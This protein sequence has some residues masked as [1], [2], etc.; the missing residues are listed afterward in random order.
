MRR[1]AWALVPLAIAASAAAQDVKVNAQF[2]RRSVQPGEPLAYTITVTAEALPGA[3]VQAAPDFSAFDAAQGPSSSQSSEIRFVN[4]AVTKRETLTLSWRV[5]AKTVEGVFGV[6]ATTVN[7]GGQRYPVP[8]ARVQVSQGAPQAQQ[9]QSPWQPVDPFEAMRQ[10]R[11]RA[12]GRQPWQQPPARKLGEGVSVRT[13]VADHQVWQGQPVLVRD[14]LTFDLDVATFGEKETIEF[15]GFA[16]KRND[17]IK[18]EGRQVRDPATGEIRNEATLAEWVIVPL[19]PGRKELPAHVYKLFVRPTDPMERMMGREYELARQ[20][21][22]LVLDVRPLP[23]GAPASF[24]GA[25]GSFQLDAKVDAAQLKAGDGT[26][27]VV[28]V[29]GRGSFDGVAAPA[30]SLP[31]GIKSFP[32]EVVEHSRFGADGGIEGSK[33]F[34]IPLLVTEAGTHEIPSI[35]WSFF[36]PQTSRYVERRSDPLVIQ[37]AEGEVPI[38]S[39]GPLPKVTHDIETQGMDIRHVRA[40]LPAWA[41]DL[42]ARGLPRWLLLLAALGPALN[43]AVALAGVAARLG[44][45]DPAAQR[46]AEAAGHAKKRLAQAQSALAARRH[47]DAADAASKAVSGLVSDRLGLGAELAPAEAG[48][49]IADAGQPELARRVER[50]LSDCDFARFAAAGATQVPRLLEEAR[51]LLPEVAS[52]SAASVPA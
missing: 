17:T 33:T 22:P 47:V 1:A 40:A 34:T 12:E 44:R 9:P 30:V 27:L 50:F 18:P 24:G 45:R 42:S 52:L 3:R 4:G 13:E 16:K 19:T 31:R 25:V 51:A 5:V 21:D 10:A 23:E 36:D 38:A 11:A 41:P 28:T 20:T 37:A 7:V 35:A 43:V 26:Q 29:R 2:D 48:R 32:P 15:P 8:E 6:P 49:A 14:V 46:A 39:A